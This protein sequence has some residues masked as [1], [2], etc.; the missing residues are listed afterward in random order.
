MPRSPLFL[1]LAFAA[2]LLVAGFCLTDPRPALGD[3]ED[4]ASVKIGYV[5]V[6]RLYNEYDK[7][8]D[9][10]AALEQKYKGEIDRLSAEE[11]SIQE[12]SK[13]LE[14]LSPNSQRFMTLQRNLAERSY[15]IR[16]ELQLQQREFALD[17]SDLTRSTYLEVLGEID[18]HAQ[19]YGFQLILKVDKQD[20]LENPE[21]DPMKYVSSRQI[22]YHAK[23]RDITEDLVR[24]LNRNYIRDR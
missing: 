4:P 24:G 1:I 23:G 3:G 8:S 17:L 5:D 13:Q 20:T 7:V 11:K 21:V 14:L 19:R 10:K 9:L 6:T 16:L 22:L 2:L 15:K 12:D 18:T